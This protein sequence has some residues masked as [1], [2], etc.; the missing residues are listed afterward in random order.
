MTRKGWEYCLLVVSERATVLRFL[1]T[2]EASRIYSL[3]QKA[4]K[5][6]KTQWEDVT[7]SSVVE[8]D[9]PMYKIIGLLGAQG[10]EMVQVDS[11]PGNQYD[12]RC[13]AWGHEHFKHEYS[14]FLFKREMIDGDPPAPPMMGDHCRWREHEWKKA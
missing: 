2:P 13:I 11:G 10:W 1:G 6:K 3:E 4:V 7:L 8:H 12:P 9:Y 5:R 14:W